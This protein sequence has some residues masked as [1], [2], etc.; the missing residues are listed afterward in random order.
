MYLAGETWGST[1]KSLIDRQND[2]GYMTAG[3]AEILKGTYTDIT[4]LNNFSW[5]FDNNML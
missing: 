5:A 2:Q 4:G 3:F 1:E